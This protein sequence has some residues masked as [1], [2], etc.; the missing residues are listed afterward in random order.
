MKDGE[1]P[2]KKVIAHVDM[3]AF[4][5]SVEQRQNPHLRGKPVLVCGNPDGRSVVA[6]SSYEARRYGVKTGMTI[7]QAK[8]LCPHAILVQCDP[9]KYVDISTR[10]LAIYRSFT[11]LVEAF[12]VDEAFLDLQRTVTDF[13]QNN[14]AD[15][16][17]VSQHDPNEIPMVVA[18]LSHPQ[19]DDLDRLRQTAENNISNELVRLSGV[20]DVRIVG[21]R[22]REVSI[23]TDDYTLEAYGLT[24]GQLATVIEASNRNMTG[25]SIVEMGLR[26]V[27]RA[28]GEYEHRRR[29]LLAL[30][31][32]LARIL[33]QNLLH[34]PSRGLLDDTG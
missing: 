33:R 1:N 19:I 27:I 30:A 10:L 32:A 17:S 5:A 15:E 28:V 11:P 12:S 8:K 2:L 22:R 16:I 6:T 31:E 20:A 3:N 18:I 13:S 25:G 7:P 14:Q 29:G 9:D 24:L 34:S 23:I 21:E 26:Y 4:F